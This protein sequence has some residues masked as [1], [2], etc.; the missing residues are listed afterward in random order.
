MGVFHYYL[1]M[2]YMSLLC[3]IRI[4]LFGFLREPARIKQ[5]GDVNPGILFLDY[6]L[7]LLKISL[8][9]WNLGN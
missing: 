9:V 3:L 6:L 2:I 8:F 4:F 7:R 1:S 5:E